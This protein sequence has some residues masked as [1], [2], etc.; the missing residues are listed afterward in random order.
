MKQISQGEAQDQFA[1][2]LYLSGE[3]RQMI[4]THNYHNRVATKDMQGLEGRAYL[5]SSMSA[6]K[7]VNIDI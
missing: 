4:N 2:D 1:E 7:E 5:I 3:I 6:T